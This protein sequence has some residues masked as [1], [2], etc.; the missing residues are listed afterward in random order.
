MILVG[1]ILVVS[2]GDNIFMPKEIKNSDT[3]WLLQIC[4][5]FGNLCDASN[6]THP[7]IAK[8]DL[9]Y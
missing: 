4:F 8:T 6:I 9:P 7:L 2:S 3:S 5:D 1:R